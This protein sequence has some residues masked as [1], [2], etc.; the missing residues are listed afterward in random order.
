MKELPENTFE[1]PALR[2]REAVFEDRREAGQSLAQLLRPAVDGD[3]LV[4]A[5]PA[6]G[7]PVAR[8][9]ADELDLE[10]DALVV[11]KITLPWNTEAGFGARRRRHGTH[12]RGLPRSTPDGRRR[13]REAARDDPRESGS[14]RS[15]VARWPRRSRDSRARRDSGRRPA[16]LGRHD[17]RRRRLGSKSRRRDCLGRGPHRPYRRDRTRVRTGKLALLR[18]CTK[19]D[20]IRRRERLRELARRP[21]G[22]SDRDAL[23]IRR[24]SDAICSIVDTSSEM[25][26]KSVTATSCSMCCRSAVP[27]SGTI[28]TS[29]ANRKITWGIVLSC[30]SAIFRTGSASR[31]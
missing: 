13:G 29:S 14:P 8:P 16:R 21:R 30:R 10:L 27:V 9:L 12:R 26:S 7:V 17:A 15:Q 23:V 5:I 18:K 24:H 22:R 4:L 19:Q 2:E 11:S 31:T 6:G 28:P 1:D 20:S 25:S 3:E